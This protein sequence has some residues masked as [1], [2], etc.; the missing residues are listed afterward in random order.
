MHF[1]SCILNFENMSFTTISSILDKNLKQKTGL[2]N[3]VTAALIC[4]EFKKIISNIFGPVADNKVKAMYFRQGTL[5]IASLS[6]PLAQ[7]I[8]LHEI[9]ILKILNKK[10]DN[11][12]KYIR[13][14]V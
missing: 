14:L 4:D 5:T 1:V 13:Y 9:E 3:Q 6:S 12:I 8:K 2:A 10:F 7:E 11:V